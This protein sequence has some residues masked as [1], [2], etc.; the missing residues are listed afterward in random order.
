MKFRNYVAISLKRKTME[1]W[2]S[3]HTSYNIMFYE[4]VRFKRLQIIYVTDVL[5][6]GATTTPNLNP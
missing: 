2:T 3:V 1:S 4:F 5:F 6:F